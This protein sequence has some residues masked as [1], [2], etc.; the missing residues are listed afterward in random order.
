MNAND[1]IPAV[2]LQYLYL[3]LSRKMALLA[4]TLTEVMELVMAIVV[5]VEGE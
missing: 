1:N 3:E 2:P 4:D 5:E